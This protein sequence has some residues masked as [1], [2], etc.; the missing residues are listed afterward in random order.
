MNFDQV[1]FTDEA[2]FSL[3]GPDQFMSWQLINESSA[4]FRERKAFN[5]GGIL[6]HGTLA[7]NGQLLL[8]KIDGTLNS[9]K[10]IQILK[11]EVFTFLET[12]CGQNW[13]LQQDNARP[14]IAKSTQSLFQE[15]NTTTIQWPPYSPDLSLIENVWK[16]V[17]DDV[18]DGPKANSVDDLLEKVQ[19]SA[20][21]WNDNKRTIFYK[22]LKKLTESYLDVVEKKVAIEF[23]VLKLVL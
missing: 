4:I 6:V 15:T 18:Y 14:Y 10:Y 22:M 2:R 23:F 12:Q 20:Q 9:Q 1:A 5:G 11:N 3:C 17:K 7:P 16:I 8:L 19:K 13:I 21:N